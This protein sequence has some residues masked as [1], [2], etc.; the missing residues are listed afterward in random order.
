MSRRTAAGRKPAVRAGKPQRAT[1]RSVVAALAK[2]LRGRL[3]VQDLVDSFQHV[4]S[5]RRRAAGELFSLRDHLRG[6]AIAMLAANRPW[7]GIAERMDELD[8]LFGGW[9]PSFL[10]SADPARLAAGVRQLGCGNARLRLQMAAIGAHIATLRRMEARFGHVD[11]FL[12]HAA[13]ETVA[14]LISA[15]RSEWKLEEVGRQIAL[16]WLENVGIGPLEP[17]ADVRRVLGPQRLA[18]LP[19]HAPDPAQALAALARSAR[20]EPAA[21]VDQLRMFARA[22]Y[23]GICTATP[24]CAECGV[25]A[26]CRQ[27]SGAR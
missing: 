2:D 23:A 14:S 22:E 1:P 17:D 19:D 13:P 16:A 9:R 11:A 26:H 15:P 21:L 5:A 3:P 18:L 6:I 10:E 7:R 27:G 8:E 12:T 4:A 25:R 20:V 24:N